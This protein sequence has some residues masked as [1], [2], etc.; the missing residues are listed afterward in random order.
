MIDKWLEE[1]D[2][3]INDSLLI[4][5]EDLDFSKG[6]YPVT[7]FID[8]N[9]HFAI[10]RLKDD[11]KA[12]RLVS[13]KRLSPEIKADADKWNYEFFSDVEEPKELD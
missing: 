10:V 2:E 4:N 13:I 11:P 8:S 6:D 3:H 1:I 5:K 12:P 9:D 7:M